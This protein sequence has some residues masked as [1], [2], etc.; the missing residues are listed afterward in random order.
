[1]KGSERQIWYR[2]GDSHSIFPF[3]MQVITYLLAQ[4]MHSIH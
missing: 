2:F 1:M 4:K 3:S